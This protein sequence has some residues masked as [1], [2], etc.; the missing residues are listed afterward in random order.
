MV[1]LYG[2]PNPSNKN[3]NNTFG[4]QNRDQYGNVFT[5]TE[6]DPYDPYRRD[7]FKFDMQNN[8]DSNR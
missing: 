3:P 1:Q 6:R 5:S 4:Q 7:R 8:D 2:D